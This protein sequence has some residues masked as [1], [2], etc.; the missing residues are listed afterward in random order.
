MHNFL[1]YDL[2]VAVCIAV[3]YMFYRLLLSKE[4]F[5]RVN[6][7]VLLST[8]VL[9]FILPLCVITMHET[10]VVQRIPQ[11]VVGD[12][13]ASVL[14]EPVSTIPLWQWTA[15]LLYIVGAVL[16]L[17]KTFWSIGK[18]VLLIRRSEQHPLTD[19][20]I[21]CVT[22]NTALTP[23]SWMHY[24]VMNRSD[25]DLQDAAI[26]AHERGHIRMHHSYDVVLVDI[27]TAL[28]WFNPAMWMLRADLRAIHEYE[29]D[30]AVLSQGINA[31]QYQYLLITK[32]TGIGGYSIANGI[33]HSTLKNR[34]TMM[35]H[36]KSQASRLLKLLAL[37]PIVG[38][39]LALNAE[40][41]TDVVYDQPQKNPVAQPASTTSQPNTKTYT[42]HG[43][44]K[45]KEKKDAIVGAVIRISGSKLGT[46]TDR[47]GEFSL[48]AKKGDRIEV[49]YVGYAN[50]TVVVSDPQVKFDIR[51]QKDDS[52][53]SS[54]NDN[55]FDV[56]EEMPQ[57]PGGAA[58]LMQYLSKN[59]RYPEEAHKNNIQGRVIVN[60]IV[61]TDGS[62]T[63]AKVTRSIHP[64]LDAEALR[65]INA[66]PKWNPG[67]QG[68]KPVRV[69]YTVPVTFKLQG[70]DVKASE[71][72]YILEIDGKV[73]DDTEIGNI[74]SGS[75]AS[76]QV[77]KAENGQPK[78][79][80]I[81]TKKK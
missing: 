15:V 20:V 17:C 26:L 51:L 45:D 78:K 5:H 71:E 58:A 73:V 25:Y 55:P 47:N 60:F 77:V 30:A 1:I 75:I 57:F 36:K 10:V 52:D 16:M 43:V 80:R 62:I 27:L 70:N 50:G 12:I 69:K 18:V 21:V 64:L 66:M 74:P 48:E 63:E 41:V 81:T 3:F 32:A 19:G 44:V 59:I 35:L 67:M 34:I 7:I 8:A 13:E 49:M 37:L 72:K 68:G 79:I 11:V 31:R 42:I 76:M 61:E 53:V 28:Q 46:V 40:T 39:A 54:T 9:S 29:A 56:V 2:K 33:S 23:F 4:T 65:V 24:I 14:A 22:G 38:T 6:R